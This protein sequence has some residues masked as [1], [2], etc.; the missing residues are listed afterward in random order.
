MGLFIEH[1][2]KLFGGVQKDSGWSYPNKPADSLIEM[3][4]PVTMR[5]A[6]PN[7]IQAWNQFETTFS[8]WRQKFTYKYFCCA[9]PIF[10]VSWTGER[11]KAYFS[12]TSGYILPRESQVNICTSG[13][14]LEEISREKI[15]FSRITGWKYAVIF[16]TFT[17]HNS[18]LKLCASPESTIIRKLY[19]LLKSTII[20][21]QNEIVL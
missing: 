13:F 3:L 15:L 16:Y 19:I 8:K 20:L 4:E 10:D 21:C 2:F 6:T 18:L 17:V 5:K 1:S 9:S 12:V 7:G 14:P 11:I